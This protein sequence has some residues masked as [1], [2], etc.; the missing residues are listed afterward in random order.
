MYSKR[1]GNF[2][3]IITRPLQVLNVWLTDIALTTAFIHLPV[4]CYIVPSISLIF[5]YIGTYYVIDR[6]SM[7]F[8]DPIY[9]R[10]ASDSRFFTWSQFWEM[11]LWAIDVDLS[12]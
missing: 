10:W 5:S 4:A 3:N 1:T 7:A 6:E 11:C 2:A 9:D 12:N 8:S